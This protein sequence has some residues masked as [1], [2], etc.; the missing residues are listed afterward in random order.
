MYVGTN[1]YNFSYYILVMLCNTIEFDEYICCFN[2][3]FFF[4]SSLMELHVLLKTNYDMLKSRTNRNKY[5]WQS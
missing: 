2:L 1:Y 3:L 5:W 4:L